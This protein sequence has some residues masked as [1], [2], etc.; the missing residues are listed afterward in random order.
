MNSFTF[1]VATDA[2]FKNIVETQS[3][4]FISNSTTTFI[5]SAGKSWANCYYKFT[6]NVTVTSTSNKFIE[7]SEAKFYKSSAS[8]A[9]DELVSIDISGTYDTEFDKG[10]EFNHT[11]MTVTATYGNGDTQDVSAS[12]SFSGYDMS[13]AGTQT[14]TL[15]Y[16]EGGV[17]KNTSYEITVKNVVVIVDGVFD[18][19][20]GADYGSGL[21]PKD[22]AG[23]NNGGSYE[24]TDA[25]WTAGKVTLVTSGKYRWWIANTGDELRMYSNDG[26]QSALTLSVPSGYVITKVDFDS[27]AALSA[28]KGTYTNGS[29]SGEEASVAFEWAASSGAVKIQTITVTYTNKYTLTVSES[30]YATYY[31]SKCAYTIPAGLTGYA[32]TAAAGDQLTTTEYAAGTV[33]PAGEALVLKGAQGNYD[34]IFTT[35]DETPNASNLLKGSDA[36]E[37]PTADGKYYMLSYD[38]TGANVGFYW[39]EDN[40]AAFENGAHK[41]YLLLPADTPVKGFRFDFDATAINSIN[42]E[43][44]NGAI[45][46]LQGQQLAAPQKGINIVGGKK[47]LVK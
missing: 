44:A 46:N 4:E 27:N 18:F 28:D 29:W 21:T 12:A 6:Y 39:G 16:T 23:Y 26:D 42:A 43:T 31:N 22:N 8:I 20:Q 2:E 34:L 17:T 41:A 40:G 35:T 11:G 14:V 3:P 24:T 7:F 19:T 36:A 37:T 1:T 30:G 32:I 10:D 25:T 33:V 9:D 45:Y 15:S 5:P 13:T 38:A 47:V